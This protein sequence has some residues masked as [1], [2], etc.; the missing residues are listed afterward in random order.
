MDWGAETSGGGEEKRRTGHAG[1]WTGNMRGKGNIEG[2]W[3][4]RE[5]NRRCRNGLRN[6][7]GGST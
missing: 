6:T 7:G 4:S 5:E 1:W 2:K 3:K